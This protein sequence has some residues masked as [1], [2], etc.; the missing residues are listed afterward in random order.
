MLEEEQAYNKRIEKQ[1]K[2]TKGVSG[3]LKRTD[4]VLPVIQDTQKLDE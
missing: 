4:Y 2:A 3:K 1:S